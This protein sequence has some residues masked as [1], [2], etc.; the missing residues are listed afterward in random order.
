MLV[1]PSCGVLKIMYLEGAAYMLW[2][3]MRNEWDIAAWP[4]L[5]KS[6]GFSFGCVIKHFLGNYK[7]HFEIYLG[8]FFFYNFSLSFSFLLILLDEMP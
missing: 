8:I 5:W 3:K 4:R 2:W 7:R 1:G 6:A